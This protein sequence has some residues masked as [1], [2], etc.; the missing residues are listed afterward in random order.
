LYNLTEEDVKPL[1]EISKK[2]ID[3]IEKLLLSNI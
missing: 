2:Y 3:E 1:L